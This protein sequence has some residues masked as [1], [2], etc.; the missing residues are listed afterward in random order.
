MAETRPRRRRLILKYALLGLSLVAAASAG[1]LLLRPRIGVE[2]NAGPIEGLTRELERGIPPGYRPVLFTDV[3]AKAGLNFRHFPGRRSTQLPEDMGSGAAWGDYDADGDFDL[4][5]CDITTGPSGG[6]RL[7][8]NNGDGT[9]T[10]VTSEAG[11]GYHGTGMGAAWADYDNDGL[12]DLVVTSY[13]PIL[14]YRN[15][16]GGS[17]EDVSRAAGLA[18]FQGFWTGVSWA[19]YDRDGFADF[20]VCGYVK[21]SFQPELLQRSSRQYEAVVPFTLNPSSYPPERNLLFHNNGD[22]TFTEIARSAGVDN[23]T[24]RSLSAAW[25]DFDG[26]DWPDLYVANDVS[27]NAMF[28]NR[29]NGTFSDASHSAWVADYRGAMGLAVGDWDCDGDFDIFVTHWIA[30]ENA[31]YWNQRITRGLP[32]APGPLRFTDVADML[33]LGQISLNYIG[34]GTS[35]FDFDNDG[36]LDLFV[37]NGSTFQAEQDPSR[38]VGMKNLLFW[39]KSPQ[40]GFFEVGSASGAVFGRPRVARGAAFADYDNDGDVDILV[41]NHSDAPVLLQNAANNRNHW[42]KVRVQPTKSNRSGFGALLSVEVQGSRQW[43]QIGSQSSYLSQ[44]ALE[45]HFGLGAASQVERITVRFP[46][47]LVRELGVTPANRTV[48]ITE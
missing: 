26:D 6:N 22:G 5:I 39:Q 20:Y 2:S 29:R 12:L 31:L 35:F 15:R 42:L 41:V 10:D 9:F 37:A 13:G 8:R 21:Y 18:R 28:L 38:L 44:N 36:R 16:G 40:E 25:A 1:L 23:P 48:V 34:W 24:G 11:V 30:Q 32:A 45:A 14:L 4:Y 3:A 19:D 33:G 43:Q 46:S 17:F 47:G 27:D 7:F